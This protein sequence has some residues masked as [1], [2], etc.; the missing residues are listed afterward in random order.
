[1]VIFKNADS[2][3]FFLTSEVSQ[4]ICVFCLW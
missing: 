2:K 4:V 1:M 3:L